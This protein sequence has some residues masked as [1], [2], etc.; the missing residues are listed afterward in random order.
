MPPPTKKRR[1]QSSA[2]EEITFDF[3]ARQD[4]LTGF[5]KRK[6]ERIKFAQEVAAKKAREE[7]LE[8]RKRMREGRKRDLEEHV[9]AVNAAL[10]EGSDLDE[11]GSGEED[12]GWAGF[13]GGNEAED[14][15]VNA[16]P[17]V[18]D[19]ED[20]YI[21][22]DKYTTVTVEAMDVTRDGLQKAFEVDGRK[23]TNEDGAAA[24]DDKG[25]PTEVGKPEQGK[26]VWTKE[27]PK[28]TKDQP[29]KK[30]RKFRY[31]SKADRK[32]TRQKEKAGNKAKAKE[33]R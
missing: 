27:K 13:G 2:P 22:E 15:A 6:L 21:D 28:K 17:E 25:S 8:D 7:K 32:V 3:T 11:N 4:Y 14:A 18:L 12:E 29:K 31:E 5:H 16:Q 1:T 24:G 33:R 9:K 19:R 30:K 23:P 26:R 20:E 10:R